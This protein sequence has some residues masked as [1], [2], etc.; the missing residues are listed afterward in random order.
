MDDLCQHRSG[1]D[2]VDDYVE[3]GIKVR[4]CRRCGDPVSKPQLSQRLVGGVRSHLGATR[5]DEPPKRIPVEVHATLE[6][7]SQHRRNRRLPGGLR[8]GDENDASHVRQH[9]GRGL[10]L[11]RCS[12]L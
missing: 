7:T 8:A 2:V 10:P 12:E 9:I 6:S 3:A 4:L 5:D 11:T 1:H